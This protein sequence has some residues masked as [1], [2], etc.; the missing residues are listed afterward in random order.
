MTSEKP[1]LALCVPTFNR[2]RYLANLLQTVHREMNGFPHAYE[3]IISDNASEDDTPDVVEQ[4]RTRLPIRSF[5]QASNIGSFR[6]YRFVLGQSNSQFSMYLADDDLP[7]ANGLAQALSALIADPDVVALYAPWTLVDLV[8]GER[9]KN[10]YDLPADAT[11]ERAN[12]GHL[13]ALILQ[14]HIFPE[15]AIMRTDV[16]Q[17]LLPREHNL[18][19]WAFTVPAEYLTVGKLIF[20]KTPFYLSV[21]NYFA[22]ER[23]EQAG[24][25]QVETSWDQYEGGL[26]HLLGLAA[27]SLTAETLP[28]LRERIRRFV[29]ERMVVALR[30]RTAHGR[31]P[32]ESYFLAS[33]LR[34]LGAIDLLPQPFE[35]IRAQAALSFLTQDES[36]LDGTERIALVGGFETSVGD[37]LQTKTGLPAAYYDVYPDDMRDAIVLIRGAKEATPIDWAAEAERSNK[38]IFETDLMNKFL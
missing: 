20:Q 12:F 13:L 16:Y 10:F 1:T 2:G 3:L 4:W 32:I 19:F 21:T 11:I 27:P 7:D 25:A 28:I 9:V 34:G 8:K 23:R 37:V 5:R 26:E 6:N 22:D 38:V 35:A 36:L 30:V 31:D 17:R 24:F 14:H 15:I 18:A 29:I 33:R